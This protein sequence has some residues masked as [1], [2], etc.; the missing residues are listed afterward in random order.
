MLHAVRM[1]R[2][3][4]DTSINVNPPDNPDW[5]NDEEFF[6]IVLTNIYRSELGTLG[7]L[8]PR[9]QG[10]RKDHKGHAALPHQLEDPRAFLGFGLNRSRFNRWALEQK[11][12]FQDL[13]QV[14]CPFNPVRVFFKD[15]VP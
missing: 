5:S 10:L 3:V 2:D 4:A 15:S 8:R 7:W 1:L 13:R 12:L 14:R 11:E 6:A 9:R